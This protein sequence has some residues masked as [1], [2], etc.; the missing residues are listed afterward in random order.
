MVELKPEQLPLALPKRSSI[1]SACNYHPPSSPQDK[2]LQLYG[3]DGVKQREWTLDAV[4]R[5][6]KVAGGPPKREALL[7]GLKNGQVGRV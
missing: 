2:K 6:I 4:I 3:F 1:H 7:V 5:Y